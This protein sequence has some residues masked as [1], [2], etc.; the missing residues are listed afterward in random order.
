[1]LG[2][3]IHRTFI[4]STQDVITLVDIVEHVVE[5]VYLHEA[6]VKKLKVRVPPRKKAKP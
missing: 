1:M 3:Q 4:P 2:M 5:T 6:K